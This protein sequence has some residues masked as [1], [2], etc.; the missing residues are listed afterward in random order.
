MNLTE[1]W[2]IGKSHGILQKENE[3]IPFLVF[4]ENSGIDFDN[5]LEIGTHAGGTASIM[6][7]I[8][9]NVYG[10]DILKMN[11]LESKYSNFHPIIG[12]SENIE[13]IQKIKDLNIKFDILFIDGDHEPP[14]FS[15]DFNN[16]LPFV[17]DNGLIVFH[18][19][20]YPKIREFY[21][22]LCENY[23]NLEIIDH[24]KKDVSV[25]WCGLGILYNKTHLLD[26]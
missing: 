1:L 25:I 3:F 14:H 26:V 23:K 2:E 4:I 13:I 21:N 8:F 7:N 9:K 19:I 5:Y 17:K 12:N 15:N 20:T 11:K 6:C 16:Y 18:D 24:F 22:N 10:I